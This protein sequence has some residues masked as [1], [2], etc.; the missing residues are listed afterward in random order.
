MNDQ[1]FE[2]A[3]VRVRRRYSNF[4][5]PTLTRKDIDDA[6]FREVQVISAEEHRKPDNEV[7]VMG[8]QRQ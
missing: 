2:E 6:I 5:W 3:Y 7:P 8:Q 4:D 1:V